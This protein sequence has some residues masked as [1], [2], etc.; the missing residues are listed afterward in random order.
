LRSSNAWCLADRPLDLPAIPQT[1]VALAEEIPPLRLDHQDSWWHERF[2][3]KQSALQAFLKR[4]GFLVEVVIERASVCP[5]RDKKHAN[6]NVWTACTTLAQ[7]LEKT[8]NPP[9]P[10]DPHILILDRGLFDSICWL[11]LME[12]LERIRP[13]EREIIEAFLRID[14]WRKRIS[15]VFAMTVSPADAMSREGGLLPVQ[16]GRG[17]IMPPEV[18]QQMLKTTQETAD[19]MKSDFRIFTIDTSSG[20]P[21]DGPRRTAEMVADLTLNIID[22]AP[23]RGHSF[24]CQD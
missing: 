13:A 10:D 7:V 9:K 21:K 18:L 4:C 14:D 12:R 11:T 5:I 23:A 20:Q 17:S 15:G 22:G 3:K 2:P 16:G 19:R 8:Q 24:D 1:V 6:F